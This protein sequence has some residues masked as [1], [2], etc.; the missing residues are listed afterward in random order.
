MELYPYERDHL[1]RLRDGLAECMVLLK[2]NGAF[3]LERA[4][5]LAAYGNGVRH[6]V[7]GGT[8]SG[9]V[10]ARFSVNIEQGLKEAGFTL[11]SS[12]WLDAYDAVRERAKEAFR[13]AIR[14]EARDAGTNVFMYGMGAVMP[15]PEYNLPVLHCADAA[16]Y[17]LSR[18]S[19]EGSDRRAIP[20][21]VLLTKTEIRDILALNRMYERFMLVLNVG[22]PVDLSPVTEVGNILLLSQLGTEMGSAL[23][24]VLLGRSTPSGKLTT[25][26][27][28][29]DDYCPDIDLGD[30]EETYYYEGVYVGYRFFSTVGKKA[31][32]P[33]GYG[34]SYT[35]FS[36]SDP[37]TS[38]F[39]STL[40]F[41]EIV[42]NVGT[43]KGREVVQLYV[44]PPE[45]KLGRPSRELVGFSKTRELLPGEIEKAEISFDLSDMACFDESRC[46]YVLEAGEYLLYAGTDS[47]KA[48]A[49]SALHLNDEIILKKV[50]PIVSPSSFREKRY[51]RALTK[52]PSRPL[53]QLS[54]D[55]RSFSA[56]EVRYD[57]EAVIEDK[58]RTLSNGDLADLSVGG[59]SE[60]FSLSSVIGN[61]ARHVAG[62]AGETTSKLESRGIGSLVMAD[63]PAGLRLSKDYYTASDGAHAVGE[64][65]IMESFM[66]LMDAPTR[67]IA[68]LVM[69]GVR[70]PKKTELRHQY[71]TAI[72][73]GTAIAQS[74]NLEFARRCGDIVGE[75]ME[76][77]GIHLWLAP[78]LNIHRS[79]LCGRNFEYFSED[80]LVSGKMAAAITQSVQ[81]HKGCGTTIKHFAANNQ[82]FNRYYSNSNVSE[83][84]LREIYLKGFAICIRE[85]RP[86]AV[87]TS[88]NLLN[89]T[90]TAETRG[91]IE[92]YLRAENAFDGIVM[93]D[94][95]LQ[96]PK[97][98]SRYPITLSNKVASAGGD[99]TMP[100]CKGDRR[101]I[102]E[103]LED[104]TLSRRQMEINCSRVLRM[105]RK[106]RG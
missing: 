33:F 12:V 64:S 57:E 95:I 63:G 88:Y 18:I 83:R 23:A 94:W 44:C 37:R 39:G 26:W 90:H 89:G 8:G 68:S 35:E 16:I 78:A 84:A 46:A 70:A 43:R 96:M 81:A 69:R 32:F 73:I 17:V 10:N 30:R 34:L 91:L 86:C 20:G 38:L 77:F 56:E 5:S 105:I 54:V 104:G 75:E 67:K 85:A 14:K 47:E 48:E 106:L 21:D 6:S 80:P 45:G 52:E 58:I 66:D 7:K 40:S 72:P 3:P 76:R 65:S 61:A 15:E 13:K 103:A 19:G 92:D 36:L 102:L 27:A 71:C 2:K 60:K 42:E 100:G 24:D 53:P 97:L 98:G 25:T 1:S 41:S 31:L 22:G 55:A 87:M 49:V 50:R 62:A 51:A 29:W 74:W 101:H 9:E 28:A 11:T 4:S 59:Y 99:L 93:T 79:I 82:E